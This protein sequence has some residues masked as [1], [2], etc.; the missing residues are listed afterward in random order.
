MIAEELIYT[1]IPPE[2]SVERGKTLKCIIYCITKAVIPFKKAKLQSGI[3]SKLNENKL[4]QIFVEQIR[5]Q[6]AK[7]PGIA[8]NTSY[9]DLFFGTKGVP[10]FY[11]YILEEG[12]HNLPLLVV[13]SKRLPAPNSKKIREKEYVLGHE[14]N[15]GIERYKKEIHGKNLDECGMIG[16]IEKH[17][18]SYWLEKINEW[19]IDLTKKNLEWSNDEI[20][21]IREDTIDYSYLVSTAKRKLSNNNV[22]LHHWWIACG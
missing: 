7:F 6:L 3:K 9:S 11:F 22:F 18:P 8:V 19:I 16:F 21:K 1:D 10:D 2:L 5:V 13:E 4:T 20:L 12:K 14:N 17:T 15:G